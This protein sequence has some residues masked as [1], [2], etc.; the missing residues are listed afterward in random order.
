MSK[1]VDS[2]GLTTD[3]ATAIT[4]C[5]V[6][7]DHESMTDSSTAMLVESFETNAVYD[8]DGKVRYL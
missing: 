4:D 5:A 1:C 3:Q 8:P 7:E 2:A 6:S